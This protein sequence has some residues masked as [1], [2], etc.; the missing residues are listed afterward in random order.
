MKT[1]AAQKG[2]TRANAR[3]NTLPGARARTSCLHVN[4]A[5][6]LLLMRFL[7][8]AA[9]A[10]GSLA[11]FLL[12]QVILPNTMGEKGIINMF[13]A[14]VFGGISTVLGLLTFL[15]WSTEKSTRVRAGIGAILGVSTIGV[16]LFMI[17]GRTLLNLP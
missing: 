15:R 1:Y 3:G 4:R 5:A 17:Y 13:F 10:L 12:A 14:F 9:L 11:A 7:S 16:A 8:W 2:R 6:N